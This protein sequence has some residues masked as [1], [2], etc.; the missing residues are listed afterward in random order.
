MLIYGMMSIAL[1]QEVQLSID[2]NQIIVGVPTVLTVLA[3]G[4]EEEPTPEVGELSIQGRNRDAVQID[5]LG[6]DPMVSRQTSIINGRRSDSIDVRY[7]YRYR[8]M[9]NAEGEYQ[10]PTVQV[11]QG[12]V[13]A[14][15]APG[16]FSVKEA[17]TSSDMEIELTLPEE[18]VWVG[19]TIPLYVDVYLQRDIGDLNV[20]VPLFDELPV[21]PASDVTAQQEF[22]LT[23][24]HG[25][26]KLPI[27]QERVRKDNQEYTRVRMMAEATLTRPGNIDVD[28]S[29]ILAQMVVGQQRGMMGFARNQY[30][31]F[32]AKDAPKRLDIRPLPLQG[33]PE[34]FSDAVGEA[35]SMKTIAKK[36]VV[37][38]GEPIPIEIEI[39][40]KGNLD[41]IQ[42]PDFEA[43]GFDERIFE[44]PSQKPIGI[45]ND[46]GAK[47]FSFSV[48]LKSSDIREIPILDF[49]YFDPKKGTYVHAYTDPVALSVSGSKVVS[50][51]QVVSANAV[52]A[53]SDT[54]T[55]VEGSL[56]TSQF[57]LSWSRADGGT[58][59]PWFMISL[60][61][62][63][64]AVI[65]FFV[66][67][68]RERTRE[69][70]Q[71]R[72]AQ[73]SSKKALSRLTAQIE[74][75]PSVEIASELS[76]AL[77]AVSKDYP[78]TQATIRE[79]VQAIEIESYSPSAGSK[80]FSDGVVKQ[81]KQLVST[82]MLLL[83]VL[84]P[85]V[86]QADEIDDLEVEYRSAIGL[87]THMERQTSMLSIQQRLLAHVATEPESIPAWINLGTVSLQLSD[88]GQA[89]RAYRA[90]QSL[91]ASSPLIQQNLSQI[92]ATLPIWAQRQQT[93]TLGDVLFW[94]KLPSSSQWLVLNA[95]ILV[96]LLGRFSVRTRWFIIPWTALAVGLLAGWVSGRE[97][98]VV[99]MEATP[100][101]T[102]DHQ[103]ATLVRNE[104]MPTGAQFVVVQEQ[105]GWVQVE[106][107]SGVQGWLPKSAV[108]DV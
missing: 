3:T 20:V 6:V 27:V 32:Q 76:A 56:S 30:Q 59:V 88:K 1:A 99:V 89:V 67:G 65:G 12:D 52:E 103:Q 9:V 8:L 104:W 69:Q 7:A 82:L 23:T 13:S 49:G 91:G 44:T 19:Q 97:P 17:P 101:R 85:N 18:T 35:F 60:G 84:T 53:T 29:K 63:G 81:V 36:T 94:T 75:T 73:Q 31:L 58:V 2:S 45:D 93:N 77:K 108:E 70:R 39:R 48:R 24:V 4:F 102:A 28:P 105:A 41:G 5:F 79:V 74:T 96:V 54:Q 62:H 16:R 72:S 57:D 64:V 95:C 43:M 87:D 14:T 92:N 71:E 25:D 90:A 86:V 33:K 55:A 22:V 47:V 51:A 80:P 21:Q 78:S 83:C 42:L 15:A 50:S 11:T 68:W 107:P 38:V 98:L 106:L 61:V 37:A 66:L 100:L 10:I 26:V 46:E 34:A 40:G